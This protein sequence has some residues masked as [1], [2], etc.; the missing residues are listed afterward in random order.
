MAYKLEHSFRKDMLPLN[1]Y[2]YLGSHTEISWDCFL[3]FCWTANH[4]T[5]PAASFQTGK[6][7]QSPKLSWE[8]Q[9]FSWKV[10]C[11]YILTPVSQILFY[12]FL[13]PSKRKKCFI[14]LLT[15]KK[16]YEDQGGVLVRARS[17][18]QEQCWLG[19]QSF[20]L[21]D[22]RPSSAGKRTSLPH[23]PIEPH[24]TPW[25]SLCPMWLYY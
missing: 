6:L 11:F 18:G 23:P 16:L 1:L 13:A 24:I 3:W 20:S 25:N 9:C 5:W 14:E 12:P 15:P 19:L 2:W 8:D 17:T 22:K 21:R 10:E 7:K 4:P